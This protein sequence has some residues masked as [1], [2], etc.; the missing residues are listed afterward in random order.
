MSATKSLRDR[1]HQRRGRE[2]EPR[3][4]RKKPDH[5]RRVLQLGDIEVQ[6][7]PVDALDLQRDVVGEHVGDAARYASY[8]APVVVAH[9]GH[10]TASGGP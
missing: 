6:V 5:A 7:H 2:G 4:P 1:V 8:R 9:H 10:L 3:W